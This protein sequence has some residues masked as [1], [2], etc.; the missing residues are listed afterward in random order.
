LQP[1][2]KGFYSRFAAQL[3]EGYGALVHGL[4]ELPVY[5]VVVELYSG[6]V[7]SGVSVK[8]PVGSRPVYGTQAHGARFTGCVQVATVELKAVE[9]S[10]GIAYRF[11]FG[12]GGE[13]VG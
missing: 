6:G 12:V 2:L 7:L 9:V 1:A 10:A 13:V 8:H 5:V 11:H 3:Y 4:V